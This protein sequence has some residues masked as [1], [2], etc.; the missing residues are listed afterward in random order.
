MQK[1]L[2]LSRG[3][4]YVTKVLDADGMISEKDSLGRLSYR[5]VTV[6]ENINRLNYKQADNINYLDGDLRSQL[7]EKWKQEEGE[8][9]DDITYDDDEMQMAKTETNE[10]Y[11]YNVNFIN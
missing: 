6:A 2:T 9:G 11:E 3:N 1:I 7:T 8:E 4:V 5:E 10:M